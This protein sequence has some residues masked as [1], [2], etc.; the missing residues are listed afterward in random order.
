MKSLAKLT[1]LS[2]DELQDAYLLETDR[3]RQAQK[4]IENQK[5]FAQ[6]QKEINATLGLTAE[7]K[8]ILS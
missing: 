4:Q 3:A 6:R 5:E 1:G 8:E 2:V 7:Q